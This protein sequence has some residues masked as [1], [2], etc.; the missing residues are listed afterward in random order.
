MKNFLIIFLLVFVFSPAF[1][2]KSKDNPPGTVHLKDNIYIDTEEISN[3]S[4]L[5]YQYFYKRLLPDDTAKHQFTLP[6]TTL[7]GEANALASQYLR[8]KEFRNYP[9]VGMTYEQALDFCQFR[10]DA[11]NIYFYIKENNIELKEGRK[12]YENLI[13]IA[14]KKVK[15]RLPTEAEWE[16]AATIPFSKK[17]EKKIKKND[18]VF[19]N[20]LKANSQNNT[21]IDLTA[22]TNS[23]FPNELG[24]YNLFGNVAEMTM[25]KGIAKGGAY[26]H[27]QEEIDVKTKISYEKP[28]VWLGFRCV[29]EMLE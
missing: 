17:S 14:P 26:I 4:W 15:Y 28:T 8:S 12:D 11:V 3:Q 2:Q 6:D 25:E 20:F 21:T 9:V 23:Y 24:L 22:P 10:T 13:K 18:G 29:A 5:E 1:A 19:G 16:M 27:P 7:W